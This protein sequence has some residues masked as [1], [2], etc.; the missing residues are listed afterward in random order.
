M[1]DVT[2]YVFLLDEDVDVWR[3]VNATHLHGNIYEIAEQ[4]YH[5]EI[6]KWEFEP[7]ERVVAEP[8]TFE[9]QTLLTAIRRQ[10]A[11]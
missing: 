2:L 3:P 10:T 7:G 1:S 6:E 9:G 8:R 5:P 11:E 4:P